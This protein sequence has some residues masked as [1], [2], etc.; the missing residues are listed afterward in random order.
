MVVVA[1]LPTIVAK[2]PLRNVV[3][4][5]SLPTNELRVSVGKASL[6]WYQPPSIEQVQVWDAAGEPLLTADAIRID[7]A[8]GNLLLD[9]RNSGLDRDRPPIDLLEAS[10]GWQ[11]HR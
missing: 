8:P 7:R 11:Q 9:S 3:L 10:R 6:S 4:S 1:L 5:A 2:T